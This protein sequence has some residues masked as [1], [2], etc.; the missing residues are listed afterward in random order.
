MPVH[1]KPA[2]AYFLH[3]AK[4]KAYFLHHAGGDDG[5]KPQ[6]NHLQ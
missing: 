4:I 2:K 6:I 5:L 1:H 3:H